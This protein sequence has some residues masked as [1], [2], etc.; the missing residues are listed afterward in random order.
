[1]IKKIISYF[2]KRWHAPRVPAAVAVRMISRLQ[3]EEALKANP[4]PTRLRRLAMAKLKARNGGYV[5][6]LLFILTLLATSGSLAAEYPWT[7]TVR[8]CWSSAAWSVTAWCA[9]DTYYRRTIP[10][11]IRDTCISRIEH[12]RRWPHASSPVDRVFFC[13]E[14]NR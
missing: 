11:P 13:V 2:Q 12:E 8:Q 1:M 7:P 6:W 14:G 3:K 9:V 5:S 10:N 4:D